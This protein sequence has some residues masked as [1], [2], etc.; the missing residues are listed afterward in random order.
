MHIPKTELYRIARNFSE[1]GQLFQGSL[2]GKIPISYGLKLV[3]TGAGPQ[4]EPD[5]RMEPVAITNLLKVASEAYGILKND[6]LGKY[7]ITSAVHA[8]EDIAESRSSFDTMNLGAMMVVQSM[9]KDRPRLKEVQKYWEALDPQTLVQTLEKGESNLSHYIRNQNAQGNDIK[10]SFLYALTVL[11]H[12][13]DQ[14]ADLGLTES[15]AEQL[16]ASK[17]LEIDPAWR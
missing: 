13:L 11:N 9:M 10:G 17:K 3:S 6:V 4:W 5:I 2:D 14:F 15:V 7:A 12:T 8:M 1:D 16:V